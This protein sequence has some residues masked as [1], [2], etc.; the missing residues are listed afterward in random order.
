MA[1]KR[2]TGRP[3]G[4][5]MDPELRR[6]PISIRID[7]ELLAV[8]REMAEERGVGY[9]TLIHEWLSARAA[10]GGAHAVRTR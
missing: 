2:K 8:I 5:T 1:R 4:T 7:P 10:R 9:Q 6:V 3:V